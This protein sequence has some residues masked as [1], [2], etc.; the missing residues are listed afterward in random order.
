G[1][2]GQGL[3]PPP[4]PPQGRP[5]HLPQGGP[6]LCPCGCACSRACRTASPTPLVLPFCSCAALPPNAAGFDLSLPGGWGGLQ[7]TATFFAPFRRVGPFTEW[8]NGWAF[9]HGGL[10]RPGGGA[11]W[12]GAAHGWTGGRG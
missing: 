3:R 11:Q 7:A 10:G 8:L 2:P 4:P 9:G 12:V 1:R 5:P 6:C